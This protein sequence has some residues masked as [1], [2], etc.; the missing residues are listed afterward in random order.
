MDAFEGAC[1]LLTY[2]IFDSGKLHKG[3]LDKRQL[4]VQ[5]YEESTETKMTVRWKSMRRTCKP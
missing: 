3:M 5:K 2:L 4:Q 1:W